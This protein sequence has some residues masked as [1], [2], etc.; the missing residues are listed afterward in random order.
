MELTKRVLFLNLKI[1]II[2]F[3]KEKKI[4]INYYMYILRK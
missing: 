4:K 2:R 1:K 3:S